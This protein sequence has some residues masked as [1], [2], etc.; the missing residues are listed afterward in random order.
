MLALT[1]RHSSDEPILLGEI[2]LAA[3]QDLSADAMADSSASAACLAARRM[4][5][6]L[7]SKCLAPFAAVALKAGHRLLEFLPLHGPVPSVGG[8]ASKGL[9]YWEQPR[10][11]MA[12]GEAVKKDTAL[13]QVCQMC[14]TLMSYSGH[15]FE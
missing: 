8:S 5:P 12:A 13:L 7:L 3:H 9:Q 4:V 15:S 1:H 14:G 6:L 11:N 10:D 2:L